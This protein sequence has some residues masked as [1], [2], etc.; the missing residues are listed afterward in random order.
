MCL[1]YSVFLCFLPH[2]HKYN[3]W[4]KC[5]NTFPECAG[6]LVTSS[7]VLM[8][9][10]WMLCFNFTTKYYNGIFRN[11]NKSETRTNNQWW[12]CACIDWCLYWLIPSDS[13][14]HSVSC[15]L[16]F[17]PLNVR[18]LDFCLIFNFVFRNSLARCQFPGRLRRRRKWVV[19]EKPKGEH[20]HP[21]PRWRPT[22]YR[23][24]CS[25]RHSCRVCCNR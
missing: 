5:E 13:L 11:S 19:P 14:V 23:G 18:H 6:V 8:C 3:C 4:S 2:S 16:L 15:C 10:G 12:G 25:L 22:T 20:Q 24:K 9:D 1:C 7:S 21:L 17:F